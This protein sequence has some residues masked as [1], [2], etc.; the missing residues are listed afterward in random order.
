MAAPL[1]KDDRN[2]I[3]EYL[4]TQ[5]LSDI[6]GREIVELIEKNT[7]IHV[8][9]PTASSLKNEV[10]DES[11]EK[12]SFEEPAINFDSL[13]ES[14]REFFSNEGVNLLYEMART[15]SN[16]EKLDAIKLIIQYGYGR[17]EKHPDLSKSLRVKMGDRKIGVGPFDQANRR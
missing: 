12:I 4:R 17:P 5:D 2:R 9:Q 15:G 1:S 13:R 8:S 10:K 14:C 7:G 6:S 16:R 11:K 3:L